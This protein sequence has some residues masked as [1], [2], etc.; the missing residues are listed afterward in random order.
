MCGT[1]H[2]GLKFIVL[3]ALPLNLTTESCACWAAPGGRL[4]DMEAGEILQGRDLAM[5]LRGRLASR[6]IEVGSLPD[7]KD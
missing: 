6:L 1:P 4:P 2:R 7:K 3:G 5:T